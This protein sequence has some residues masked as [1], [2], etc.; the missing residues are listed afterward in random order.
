[1]KEEYNDHLLREA[2]RLREE[3]K[4]AMPDGL[5]D[6]I[7]RRIGQKPR[8]R[9]V[10]LYAA[11]AATAA[12]IIA[13]LLTPVSIVSE[14]SERGTVAEKAIKEKKDIK[15]AR[16]DNSSLE[17]EA[18]VASLQREAE[19]KRK[20]QRKSERTENQPIS[21]QTKGASQEAIAQKDEAQADASTQ[22]FNER[23]AESEVPDPTTMF[24][25]TSRD[26]NIIAAYHDRIMDD[27]GMSRAY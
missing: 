1:M 4:P 26:N 13:V 23:R 9:L 27:M 17:V 22:D 5:E 16:Q 21:R 8:R 2:I 12:I 7:M 3:R 11:I 25:E 24:I 19:P 10:P 18:A 6:N 20:V 15:L 14:S